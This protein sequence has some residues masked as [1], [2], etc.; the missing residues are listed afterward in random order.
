MNTKVR[1]RD[2]I[3]LAVIVIVVGG[4]Y[5]TGLHTEVIGRIQQVLLSTTL[6]DESGNKVLE[7][8][9]ASGTL[10][11]VQLSKLDGETVM[12]SELKGKVVFM[13]IWATWCPPCVAEMPGIQRLYEKTGDRV[14]F[15]MLSVDQ[16]EEKVREYMRKKGY[17]FPVYR[18]IE[19]LP[20]ALSSPSIPA[21]FVI[22]RNGQIALKKVGMANYDN[23]DFISKLD[24]LVAAPAAGL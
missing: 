24:G 7:A 5:L 18:R 23:A 16:D 2:L 22:D 19:A 21:T 9:H 10:T 17:T 11:D 1:K 20:E 4:L 3:E 6:L 12:L 15:V 13:N 8:A 14:A